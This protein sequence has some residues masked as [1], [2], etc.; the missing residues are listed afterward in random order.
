[1]ALILFYN[2]TMNKL[3]AENDPKYDLSSSEVSGTEQSS[4]S[5]LIPD[6][7]HNSIVNNGMLGTA[8]L[9]RVRRSFLLQNKH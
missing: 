1:V 2:R 5:K 9:E 3:H 8:K 4:T 7:T 6:S